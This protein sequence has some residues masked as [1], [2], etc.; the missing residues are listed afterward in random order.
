MAEDD[1]EHEAASGPVDL[2]SEGRRPSSLRAW[3]ISFGVLLLAVVI[4]GVSR[5]PSIGQL[6]TVPPPTWGHLTLA[7]IAKTEAAEAGDAH[8][9]SAVWLRTTRYQALPLLSGVT[10]TSA[11][12]EFLVALHGQFHAAPNWTLLPHSL[13]S[14]PYLVLLVFGF[15]GSVNARTILARLPNLSTLSTVETL[16]L[17]LLPF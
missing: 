7:A 17:G 9:Q 6:H 16:H 1:P 5:P 8:P 14:G 11:D 13:Q 4:Y 2:P 3:L 12:A 10:T 15:D